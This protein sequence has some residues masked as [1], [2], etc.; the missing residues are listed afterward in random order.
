MRSAS[1]L[2][3]G[4]VREVRPGGSFRVSSRGAAGA[5]SGTRSVSQIRRH[6]GQRDG[7]DER[8]DEVGPEQRPHVTVPQP[9][10]RTRALEQRQARTASRSVSPKPGGSVVPQQPRAERRRQRVPGGDDPRQVRVDADEHRH[11]VQVEHERDTQR[12]HRVQTRGTGENPKKTPSANAAAVRSG[13]SW[14]CSSASSHLR[15]SAR[16]NGNH[17]KC[18]NPV[19]SAASAD[20]PPGH[21]PATAR[22]VTVPIRVSGTPRR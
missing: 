4:G 15:T 7:A 5:P 19:G 9:G 2:R 17:R 16:V 18:V 21:H 11:P 14:M 8:S 13:V 6:R 3:P 22:S 20:A 1:V 10:A 12:Q